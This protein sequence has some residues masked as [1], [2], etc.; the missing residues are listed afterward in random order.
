MRLESNW[1]HTCFSIEAAIESSQLDHA[2]A[3]RMCMECCWNASIKGESALPN[4]SRSKQKM[5]GG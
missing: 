5:G 1:S 3:F 4:L 2:M